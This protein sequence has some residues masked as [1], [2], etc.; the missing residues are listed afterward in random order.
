MRSNK[1]VL[2][3]VCA[4]SKT[5]LKATHT[6]ASLPAGTMS[7]CPGRFVMR[8]H[9]FYLSSCPPLLHNTS[10]TLTSI[11]RNPLTRWVRCHPE[12]S[13]YAGPWVEEMT[14]FS[15]EYAADML[16]DEWA[17]V[18]CRSPRLRPRPRPCPCSRPRP[19]PH[20][21]SHPLYG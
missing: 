1:S 13:G 2:H 3:G 19:R 7:G 6:I 11:T 8:R 21:I 18:C 20:L 9:V 10:T 12:L 16:E 4:C 17:E 5:L 15:N 14:K